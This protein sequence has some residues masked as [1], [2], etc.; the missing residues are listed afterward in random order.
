MAKRATSGLRRRGGL[1]HIQKQVKGYGTL[2]ESTGTADLQE[3]ER[4]L[5]HKLEEIREIQIYGARPRVTFEAAAERYV[6]EYGH[7]KSMR[8]IVAELK[9]VMAEI[10]HLYVDQIY[11][12]TLAAFKQQARAKGLAAGSIN[13]TL[14]HVSRVLNL[15]A[16]KWRTNG[17]TW[18]SESPLIEK[19]SGPE[20]Q[21]YPLEWEEEAALLAELPPHLRQMAL[22]DI[23]TGLRESALT[24]LRWEWEVKVPEL[25]TAVF[26][27]PGWLNGENKDKEYLLVLNSVARRVL[28]EE[29]GKHPERVFTYEGA[30]LAGM[31]NSAWK[32]AWKAAG[33][34]T[35]PRYR[36]G[37]HNLRHTFGH[38]LRAAG[39]SFE[40]RQDLLWHTAGR[41]TTRYSA[42]DIQRLIDAV[43]AIQSRTRGTVLRVIQG[44]AKVGQKVGQNVAAE[45]VPAMSLI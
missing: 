1:W 6:I 39:V 30:P 31:Y 16:R 11:D 32:R 19:V 25:G 42:P 26:V 37:V 44:G 22:F 9:R 14:A 18:L 10:G 41:V 13:K 17:K 12:D 3:A 33:L 20:K 23:N 5:A 29:R 38:R 8:T 24:E 28:D 34:P 36:R 45:V 21:A 4:F 35:D 15:C 27:C 2:Y 40:D 43:E 7:L